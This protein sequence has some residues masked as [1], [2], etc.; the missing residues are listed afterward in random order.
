MC[1]RMGTITPRNLRL[2]ERDNKQAKQEPVSF[3]KTVRRLPKNAH[4]P[5]CKK[6]PV[7]AR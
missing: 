7:A 2:F 3:R 4:A 6:E 5:A 1:S